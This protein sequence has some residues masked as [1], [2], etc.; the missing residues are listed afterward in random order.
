MHGTPLGPTP[1][2][3]VPTEKLQFAMPPMHDSVEEERRHRK[4]RTTVAAPA[5]TV[6]TGRGPGTGVR[7]PNSS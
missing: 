2:M 1:P 3:P 6:R 7:S 4:E 5:G